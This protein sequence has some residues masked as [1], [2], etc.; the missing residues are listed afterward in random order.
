MSYYL[1]VIGVDRIP[2]RRG[3]PA[4]EEPVHQWIECLGTRRSF[5]EREVGWYPRRLADHYRGRCEVW[6]ADGDTMQRV[7][8][9]RWN[10]TIG[11][12]IWLEHQEAGG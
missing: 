9:W 2:A 5:D 11:Q 7:G 10:E 12:V 3:T 4:R 6:K 1:K 8:E